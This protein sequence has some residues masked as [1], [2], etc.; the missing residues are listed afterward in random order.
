MPQ[1]VAGLRVQQGEI[2]QGTTLRAT[3]G[4][5]NVGAYPGRGKPMK[6]QSAATPY[7]IEGK[8]RLG[9]TVRLVGELRFG[10]GSGFV[11]SSWGGRASGRDAF[12][13]SQ[14]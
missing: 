8:P 11:R 5:R 9:T 10:S 4:R 7:Y 3:A 12:G 1:P 14:G 2:R 13:G 6:M